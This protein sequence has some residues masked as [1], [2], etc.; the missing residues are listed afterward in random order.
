VQGQ[1]AGRVAATVRPGREVFSGAVQR[2]HLVD[3]GSADAEGAGDLTD[4]AVASEGRGRL[5]RVR[6]RTQVRVAIVGLVDEMNLGR[7]GVPDTLKPAGSYLPTECCQH[8]RA[9]VFKRIG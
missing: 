9:E 1:Q 2:E 3:E 7:R 8:I 4:D 6:T 5:L